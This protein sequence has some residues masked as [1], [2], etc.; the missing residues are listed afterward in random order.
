MNRREYFRIWRNWN[1]DNGSCV[2]CF[3]G[4]NKQNDFQIQASTVELMKHLKSYYND[5]K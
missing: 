1:G 2:E 3:F 4:K 5:C